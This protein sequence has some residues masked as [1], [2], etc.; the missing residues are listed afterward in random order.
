MTRRKFHY[1]SPGGLGTAILKSPTVAATALLATLAISA[2]AHAEESLSGLLLNAVK[3]GTVEEVRTIVDAGADITRLDANGRS[4]LDVAIASG[5][6]DVV[7]YLMLARRLQ[8]QK[9][10]TALTVVAHDSMAPP[11]T[12]IGPVRV[13]LPPMVNISRQLTVQ[14]QQ[15][16]QLQRITSP[17]EK[18]EV[19]DK[20]ASAAEKLASAIQQL[21]SV[22]GGNVKQIPMPEYVAPDVTA[23]RDIHFYPG[24]KPQASNTLTAEN[25]PAEP[26]LIS[27][28]A[29]EASTQTDDLPEQQTVEV[30]EAP[31]PAPIPKPTIRLATEKSTP[32]VTR[33]FKS[34]GN[35]LG[36]DDASKSPEPAAEPIQND[37]LAEILPPLAP[38]VA[39]TPEQNNSVLPLSTIGSE[40]IGSVAETPEA[41]S[42]TDNNPIKVRKQE[43]YS[44]RVE[45]QRIRKSENERLVAR[46]EKLR[47]NPDKTT[48]ARRPSRTPLRKLRP[49][50]NGVVLTMGNTV[51]TGQAYQPAA[52]TG[53]VSCL[54]KRGH[55]SQFCIVSIDWPVEIRDAFS[56]NT[57]IY[58]GARAVAR[59]DDGRAS[60]IH[61]LYNSDMQTAVVDWAKKK[62][63]PPTDYWRRTI[64]PFGK[65]RKANPTFVWRSTDK[66]TKQTVVLEIRKFDDSRNVFPD[67]K[68]GSVRLYL[69]GGKPVFP[70]VTALDIM[71]IDWAARSDP[72]D[73]S[74]PAT[75]NTLPV[76]R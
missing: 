67:T 72:I 54:Q 56:V 44:A 6:F 47:S 61:A 13:A 66:K 35:F 43:S 50:L 27:G 1:P 49:A 74:L 48:N 76:Q 41:K 57:I 23:S 69:A 7:R 32:L 51:A 11:K 46:S 52:S 10:A 24:H 42:Q 65:P 36:V 4:P 18:R 73:T 20:L 45:A 31:A 55:S 75:A 22:N 28:K 60:H 59:Y 39:A 38:P 64:A 26:D 14:A 5:K 58:Q 29:V 30:A 19:A 21:A 17:A 25:M 12:V 3:T 68:H 8:N 37:Q 16:E 15:V 63:G 33:L 70:T 53:P 34:I 9:A 62:F 40:P 71:S 2:P